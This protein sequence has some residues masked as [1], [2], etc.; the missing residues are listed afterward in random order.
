MPAPVEP[1]LAAYTTF[2]KATVFVG[3]SAGTLIVHV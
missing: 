2:D 3:I 1:K